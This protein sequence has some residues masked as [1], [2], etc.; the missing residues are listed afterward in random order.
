MCV[1]SFE[2]DLKLI[3]TPD[4]DGHSSF[5]GMGSGGSRKTDNVVADTVDFSTNMSKDFAVLR[6]HGGTSALVAGVAASAVL[7]YMAYRMFKWK[8]AQMDQARQRAPQGEGRVIWGGPGRVDMEGGEGQGRFARRLPAAYRPPQP[9]AVL[10]LPVHVDVCDDCREEGYD[11]LRGHFQP[12]P[13]QP[14]V[15]PM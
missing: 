9:A 15:H 4:N 14:A 13:Q 6:L 11:V 7:V 1:G 2:A 8:K 5:F 3:L 10:P 12:Q